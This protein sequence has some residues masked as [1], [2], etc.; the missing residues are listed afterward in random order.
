M[1]AM[2][3]HFFDIVLYHPILY[4][5]WQEDSAC[6]RRQVGFMCCLRAICGRKWDD[7]VKNSTILKNE[8]LLALKP[9]KQK[10]S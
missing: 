9:Y 3:L 2:L 6:E 4:R 5:K 8:T 7:R 10:F 1:P